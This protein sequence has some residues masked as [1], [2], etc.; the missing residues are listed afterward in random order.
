MAFSRENLIKLLE[1]IIIEVKNDG[2]SESTQEFLWN[3]LTGDNRTPQ[4][5]AKMVK[6]LFGGWIMYGGN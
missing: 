3:Q 6:Y 2:M 4:D 1:Q 5:D